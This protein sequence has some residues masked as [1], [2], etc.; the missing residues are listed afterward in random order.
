MHLSAFASKG[1]SIEIAEGTK[2]V[3][4]GVVLAQGGLP[5]ETSVNEG[6]KRPKATSTGNHTT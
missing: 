4:T 1:V 2:D 5:L 6:E 3:P